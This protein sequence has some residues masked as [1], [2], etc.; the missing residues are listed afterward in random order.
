MRFP[1]ALLFIV[2][3]AGLL[4]LALWVFQRRLI[5]L[6]YPSQ[7]EGPAPGVEQCTLRSEDGLELGAWFVPAAGASVSRGTFLIFNGNAGNRSHRAPLAYALSQAGFSSL[8]VDYRGYGGNPGRPS[9]HGL[10]RDARGALSYL[11]SRSDV[12]AQRLIYFGESL[13]TG[14]A[15]ELARHHPPAALVLR[16]PFPS[17]AA[18]GRLHYPLLP[19]RT[20]LR[21]RYASIERIGGVRAPLLVIV[22]E[23]DRIVPPALSRQL[24]EA[25]PEPRHWL[26]IAGADHNDWELLAGEALVDATVEIATEAVQR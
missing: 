13:G 23:K 5:Y 8:L 26:E 10:R 21:D 25:A 4:V 9:E 7:L 1:A 15:V 2:A 19:V 3:A 24:F 12:D 20:M 14:V 16:S 22:G 18:V 17:L 6:P 11:L